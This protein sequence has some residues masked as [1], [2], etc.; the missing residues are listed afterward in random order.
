M[1]IIDIAK[2]A[3]VSKSTVSRYLNDGYVSEESRKK[4]QDVIDKT[5][6]VPSN[7]GKTLRTKKTNLIGIILPKISSETI[8]KIVDGVSE[9]IS[10]ENYNI[11]LGNTDLSIE[12]EIQYLKIFRNKNVDGVIFVATIITEKHLEIIKQM[13]VPIVIVGQKVEGYPCVYHSDYE[14]AYEMTNFLIRNNHKNIAYIGTNDEDISAGINRKEGF[15]KCLQDN[16]LKYDK[17]LIKDANFSQEG[18]YEKAKELLESRNDIDA[19]FC[20]TY[21]MSLGVLEYMR[22]NNIKIP[23]DVSLCAIGDS[24]F[25]NLI[26]PTLTTIQYYYKESGIKS[27]RMLIDILKGNCNKENLKYIKLGYNFLKRESVKVL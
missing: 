15:I 21:N 10:K 16:K 8:S 19:I 26:H 11:I 5:G 1:N 20:A 13:K 23:E 6:F 4:I 22:E 9:E 2:L 27:S 14:A 12:K 18:G 3:G 25:S 17:N 7:H 24:R